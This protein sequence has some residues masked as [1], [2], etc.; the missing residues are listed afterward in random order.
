[1]LIDSVI[2]GG[3][4]VT[5]DS[6]F[7]GS[8]AVDNGRIVGVGDREQL[9]EAR[10][11][12]DASGK[13]VMPGLMDAQTHVDDRSSLDTYRTASA[14]AALGGITTF[15]DFSWMHKEH[16]EDNDPLTPLEGIDRKQRKAE[17]SGA[18][19]DY[20]LH[21][22][23]T[24]EDPA[25]LDELDD[26]VNAGVTSF[27][28]FTTTTSNGFIESVIERLSEN[29]GVG[30]YHTED[31][32]VVE[33][34]TERAKR[35]EKGEPWDM[36]PTRPDYAEAMAA[37]DVL[38]MSQ[39][40]GTKY[41]GIHTTSRKAA[42]V[43]DRYRDD[44]SQ[45]RAETCTH[46]TVLDKSVFHRLGTLPQLAPPIRTQ[47]DIEAMFTYLDKGTLDLI[48]TDHCCHKRAT[49]EN[50]DN[51]WESP[52]GANQLQTS[53]PVFFDEVVNRRGYDPSFVVEK[54]ATN[55]A[56]TYGMPNKGTLEPGTDADI[57]VFNP[58]KT[59]EIS[60]S[61][62]AS[63][64]D[65]TLYEGRMVTGWVEKTFVRGELM[66]NNGKIVGNPDHGRFVH[67]EV[68]DWD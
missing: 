43:I 29:G 18:Y 26:C 27:K 41:F 34:Q 2:S 36:P 16:Q 32:S 64:A 60:A 33:H 10:H 55:I 19:V 62:N 14:A 15:M 48:S 56:D 63:K 21:A 12:F 35:E 52:F 42:K 17:N 6:S 20:T 23:V 3:T 30:V 22:G 65:Y 28:M 49:K 45:V 8:V 38:R 53:V 1:M 57:V 61:E 50:V 25:A 4:V 59:Y 46:Y 47:D 11:E 5:M 13:L 7:D 67:R 37:D 40:H 68:P 44:G 24:R 39:E 9:P 58:E 31:A 66:A 51:W 54:M